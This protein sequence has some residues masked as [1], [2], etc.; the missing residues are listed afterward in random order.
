LKTLIRE[1]AEKNGW[2]WEIK[3]SISP[4]AEL[5]KTDLTVVSSDSVI[6]DRCKSWVNLAGAII[7][8]K[9]PSATVIDLCPGR[10]SA[11]K[12]RNSQ[13]ALV[14]GEAFQRL[15]KKFIPRIGAIK[16]KS[17]QVMSNE[18]GNL[19]ACATNIGF[20]IELYLKA[21]LIQLDLSVPHVHDLRILYD[22]IPQPVR[23]IIEDVYN[24]KWP[25]LYGRRVSVTLAKGPKYPLEK[26]RW[27]DYKV[28]LALPDVLARSGDLFQSWR[29]IFEFT[30]PKDS[31]YQFH[32][33]EYGLL[34]CAAEAIRVEIT[35][36][37]RETREAP[38]PSPPAGES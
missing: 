19:V 28:S 1:L 9:L 3:L 18:L 24:T 16:E 12:E 29:Y 35:V 31:P 4:D 11:K 36:R 27:D 10:S 22:A 15:A 25:E 7:M 38:P 33:F 34:W 37:L 5:S 30:Q 6:L 21:L 32:Q 20:A 8:Q 13:A 14:C 23:A 17:S 2:K 26:P